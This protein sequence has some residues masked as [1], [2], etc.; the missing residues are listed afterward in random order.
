MS[1]DE[2]TPLVVTSSKSSLGKRT[3][4]LNIERIRFWG[5]VG[6]AVLLLTGKFLT[7]YAV[8]YPA[9]DDPSTFWDKLFHGAP[10]DFDETETFIYKLFHFNHTCT[11]LDFNPSKTISALVIMLHIIPVN[12][13]VI[14]HYLRITSQSEP[15]YDNLKKVT[16][17]FTPIQFIFIAYFYMVFVNSPDKE[18]GTKEG[19]IAFTLHYI[20]YCLWQFGMLLM[21]IQQCWYLHLK[22][23]IPIPCVTSKMLLIY[24]RFLM[25]LFVIYTWFVVSF[26][27]DKPAWNTRQGTPG[28]LV[29][30]VIMWTWNVAAVFI[31]LFFAWCES[32]DG[33]DTMFT[34][35]ELQ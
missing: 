30:Q 14:C 12:V 8:V 3:V 15:K 17:I 23:S 28:N 29:A 2:E 11:V 27:V 22:D 25:I 35:E 19:T 16:K 6:V 1:A 21:A 33:K 13:F 4:T 34:F 26:I 5:L 24:V 10:S 31:P 9:K 32:K 18:F 7:N 20:P